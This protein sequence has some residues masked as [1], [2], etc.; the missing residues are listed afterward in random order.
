MS[1]FLA[2]YF[3][4]LKMQ[5]NEGSFGSVWKIYLCRIMRILPVY[6]FILLFAWKFLVLFGGDELIFF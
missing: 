5:E 3:L 6:A 2:S 4:L 1:A